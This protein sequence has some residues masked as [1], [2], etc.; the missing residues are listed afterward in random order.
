MQ[1]NKRPEACDVQDP[2]RWRA[3]P[4]LAGRARLRICAVI[5]WVPVRLG[6]FSLGT[7]IGAQEGI[8]RPA[9]P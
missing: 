5:R 1:Q 6:L 3:T 4:P 8:T 7:P 2:R 9:W